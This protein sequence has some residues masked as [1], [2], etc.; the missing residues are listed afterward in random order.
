[1]I[2]FEEGINAALQQVIDENQDK[3]WIGQPYDI[4][5]SED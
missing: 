2:S 3:Q 1:M 5:P 4:Q